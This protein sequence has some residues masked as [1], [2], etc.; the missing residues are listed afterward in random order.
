L[1]SGVALFGSFTFVPL[2]ITEGTRTHPA[3]TG[4][5]LPMS[6]GA[7]RGHQRICHAG[8]PLACHYRVGAAG[9]R[10]GSGRDGHHGGGACHR[11]GAGRTALATAG[12]ALAGAALGLS[13]QAYT[14]LRASWARR[15]RR[16]LLPA[17]S[18]AQPASRCSG[19]LPYW[20]PAGPAGLSLAFAL[21]ALALA[22]ALVTAPRSS[23]DSPVTEEPDTASVR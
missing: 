10:P 11:P 3:A 7:G 20:P 4:L 12:L 15:W 16:C 9:H 14:R 19:G 13:M 1:C 2:A 17:R 8:P 21:A 6:V 18:A 23:H 5:L 22:I